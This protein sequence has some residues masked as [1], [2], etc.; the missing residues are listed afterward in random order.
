MEQYV[1]IIFIVPMNFEKDI[2][3]NIDNESNCRV[4]VSFVNN[5]IRIC[6]E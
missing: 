2:K 1:Y 5:C 3:I 6:V 4:K